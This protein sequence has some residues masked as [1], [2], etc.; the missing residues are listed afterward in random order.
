MTIICKAWPITPPISPAA[1]SNQSNLPPYYLSLNSIPNA[2]PVLNSIVPI[3]AAGIEYKR[4][5]GL[6]LSFNHILFVY[7]CLKQIYF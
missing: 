6:L 7:L 3:K 5:F 1:M 2:N 4:C